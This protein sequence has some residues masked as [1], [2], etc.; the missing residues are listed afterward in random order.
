[1]KTRTIKQLITHDRWEDEGGATRVISEVLTARISTL[2]PSERQILYCLGAA[3]VVRWT[4]LPLDV[5]WALFK[6]ASEHSGS[7]SEAE[8]Q[9]GLLVFSTSIKTD[10]GMR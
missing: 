4:E 10:D 1:M 8:L 2:T 9:H 7:G 3:V 5:Q 6:V